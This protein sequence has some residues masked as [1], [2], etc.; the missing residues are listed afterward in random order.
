MSQNSFFCHLP[1]VNIDTDGK[2]ARPCCKYSGPVMSLKNYSN[3][4][5]L[6]EM[7]KKLWTGQAP[8]EC[9]R[10]VLEERISGKSLRMLANDFHPHLTQEVRQRDAGYDAIR[11]VS[12]VGSNVCNLQCLPCE[13]GSYKRSAE[14][15]AL[16]FHLIKPMLKEIQD[17][18]N[19]AELDLE[20][21]TLCSGEPFYDKQTWR[22]LD[23][24]V[25]NGRSA[26]IKLDINTNLTGITSA[27]LDWLSKNFH[28]VLIKGSIDSYGEANDYL[29]YPSE[30]TEIHDAVECIIN[31]KQIQFVITTALSNLSLLGYHVLLQ[32]LRS[33]GIKDFFISQVLTPDVLQAANLPQTI[34]KQLLPYYRNLMAD[35]T[36][37]DR[38]Q[39]AV[40]TCI[41]ICE[42]DLPWRAEPLIHYL[43]THDRHRNTSWR[44]LWPDLAR[45]C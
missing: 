44:S 2:S 7:K 21:V 22:L 17:I 18:D 1:F 13:T 29:R 38:A 40:Q 41:N 25:K 34:K 11:F 28:E 12:V 23:L 6:V 3:N 16:G 4:A 26:K 45:I 37:T 43:D 19:I 9:G 33:K 20:T 5:V 31:H 8:K 36:L 14:L 35:L 10:C 24:L 42:N 27:K 32:Y 15:H 39:T 30:W